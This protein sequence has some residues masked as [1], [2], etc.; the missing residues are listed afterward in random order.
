M[1]ERREVARAAER[2]VLVDDGRDAVV[3]QADVRREGLLADAGA[4]G[5]ERGDAQQHEGADD[6]ALDLGAR[7]GRVAA[8]EGALEAVAQV[9][10]DV[11][12]REGAEAGGDA[13]VRLA[14]AG[15]AADDLTG[16]ADLVEGR[17][18]DDDRRPVARDPD[19]VLD[20]ERPGTHG[21]GLEAGDRV[22]G[23]RAGGAGAVAR[24][25]GG[26]PRVGAVGGRSGHGGRVAHASHWSAAD[27]G[28]TAPTAPSCLTPETTPYPHRPIGHVR[29]AEAGTRSPCWSIL[30]QVRAAQARDGGRGAVGGGDEGGVATTGRDELVVRPRLR[31]PTTVEHRDPVGV[32]HG[33]EPVGDRHGRPAAGELVERDLQGPLGRGVERRG[34]LVEDEDGRVAQDG[35][36][37]GQ[38]L[39]LPTAEPVAAG[40]DH[41]VETVGQRGDEVGDLGRGERRPQLA[42]SRLR[43][44]QQQVVAHRGVDEVALL[45]HDADDGRQHLGVEVAHVDAVDGHAPGVRVVQPRQQPGH[46]RLAGPRRPDERQRRPGGD[47]EREPC[48]GLT[49]GAGVA[50]RDA[51]DAD[52]PAHP[53][54][55]QRHRA[56]RA[57]ARRA[58]GRGTRTPVRTGPS[59]PPTGR[60]R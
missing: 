6:L 52:V 29:Y 45:R 3:E 50:Q 8:D 14:V 25:G 43:S 35:A 20:G 17:R 11:T 26:H 23:A 32:T 51:L 56:T 15:E 54:G 19:D 34:R 53:P 27:V 4:S 7:A 46:G 1:R 60:R 5:R 36:R 18:G 48:D 28:A 39:L 41:R 10:R 57:P 2:A 16:A 42:L 12:G 55:V 37:H 59:R 40:A 47:G 31:E 24:V 13:V 33:G 44:R 21:H 49:V 9:D 38:P 30:S 22:L 58:R